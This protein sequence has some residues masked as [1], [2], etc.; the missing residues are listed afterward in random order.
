[1]VV[2]G[3]LLLKATPVPLG[4]EQD[5][6]GEL[7]PFIKARPCSDTSDTALVPSALSGET[8]VNRGVH[9]NNA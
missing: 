2:V 7:N 9:E 8:G 5:G 6:S 1:M 3:W 4:K